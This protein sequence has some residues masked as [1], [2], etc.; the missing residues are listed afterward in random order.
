LIHDASNKSIFAAAEA[1]ASGAFSVTKSP[2]SLAAGLYT[3]EAVG[4]F[5]SKSSAALSVSAS[6]SAPTSDVGVYL[7]IPAAHVVGSTDVNVVGA[8]FKS[9]EGVLIKLVNAT[10]TG[11]FPVIGGEANSSGAFSLTRSRALPSTIVAGSYT[12]IAIG[13][14]GSRATAYISI[15]EEVK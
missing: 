11:D 6:D 9:G 15:V 10:S 7:N 12:A 5:G 14:K 3:I 8:G 2:G 4:E 13:D 1:N